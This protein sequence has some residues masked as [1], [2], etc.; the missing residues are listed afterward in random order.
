MSTCTNDL[1]YEL[2]TNFY[3]SLKFLFMSNQKFF[4]NIRLTP[5]I[6][7]KTNSLDKDKDI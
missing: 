1:Q 6:L 7:L 5:A 2:L 3:K 4:K